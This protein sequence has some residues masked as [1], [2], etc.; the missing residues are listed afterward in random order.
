MGFCISCGQPL[1]ISQV[2]EGLY[3]RG[4]ELFNRGEFYAAHEVLED[5][6]R[7]TS[8]AERLFLQGLI[9]VAVALHHHSTGN[10]A[11]ARSLLA[12]ASRNLREFPETYLG[13]K[14]AGFRESLVDWRIALENNS[15]LPAF[16]RLE[17]VR[18]GLTP[19]C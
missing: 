14:L 6:W 2:D 11:G 17:V 3:L 9:Q 5:V 7:P 8:G 13:I 1:P 19:E 15:P 10:L 18:G 16:P 12:R 4:I